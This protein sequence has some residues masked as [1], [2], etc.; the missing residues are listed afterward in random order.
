MIVTIN[1]S[2]TMLVGKE[3]LQLADSFMCINNKASK[4]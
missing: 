3:D 1:N 2:H 4:E